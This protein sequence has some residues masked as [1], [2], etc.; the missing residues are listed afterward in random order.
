M[1]ENR[2]R[3]WCSG[4]AKW[5][6]E[7]KSY[8][9]FQAA[10]LLCGVWL[11][12]MPATA[13]TLEAIRT[14]IHADF[15]RLVLDFDESVSAELQIV[16]DKLVIA[17][18]DNTT[19]STRAEASRAPLRARFLAREGGLPPRVEVEAGQR[20]M[21]L[22]RFSLPGRE[23]G[24]VR[25]IFDFVP[26]PA[27][28]PEKEVVDAETTQ[29]STTDV[30]TAPAPAVNYP[31]PPV[32]KSPRSASLLDFSAY[33]Q[34]EGRYF[35]QNSEDGVPG[36]VTGSLAFEATLKAEWAG[37]DHQ[38]VITPFARVDARDDGRSHVDIREAKWIGVFGALEV[39]L[40]F[41]TEFWG[42]TEAVHLVDIINQDDALED[43]DQE[44]KLGQLMANIRYVSDFGTFSF[45][46]L[47]WSRERD[48]P[49]AKGR[50]NTPLPIDRSQTQ[51][52]SSH[53][54]L[55]FTWAARWGHALGPFDIGLSYF[56]GN[57]RDPR[58]LP[59]LNE[60]GAPVLIPRY[61]VIDQVGV[62]AQGTFGGLLLKVEAIHQWND[63][64]D[65]TA[66][67]AGFEYSLYNL[68]N[69][70]GD[71]GVLAEYLYDERENDPLAPF[72]DDLFFGLRW[73]GND[74]ASTQ[75]LAGA[76]VDLEGDGTAINVEFSRRI[77]AKWL[78]SLD[79]RFFSNVNNGDPLSPLRDDDFVQLRL[80]RYF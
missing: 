67:A 73:S 16:E 25:L 62:D 66:F 50:P 28:E 77:G 60:L 19:A 55:R 10:V 76:I 79:G 46:A 44:D 71:L 45:Y 4:M 23:R 15:I 39:K 43:I 27:P 34:G 14:G 2:C 13:A 65:F 47:P 57:A 3:K 22:R 52:Q 24:G 36:H 63:V 12:S 49:G 75:I 18:P 64:E 20:M 42:V 41:D 21:L 11:F 51:W 8:R 7:R 69:G 59:G 78:I 74:V 56:T 9:A 72:E 70:A 58:L 32:L 80:T 17:L 29:P 38:V 1:T 48:F 37:G 35:P 68:A 26:A 54:D 31:A 33:V 30:V 40:G 6:I 53:E 61:D 5:A